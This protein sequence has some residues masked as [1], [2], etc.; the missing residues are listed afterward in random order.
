MSYTPTVIDELTRGHVKV[1]IVLMVG[2]RWR[3]RVGQTPDHRHGRPIVTP[4]TPHEGG[5]PPPPSSCHH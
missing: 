2:G 1:P 3:V 5:T 4:T